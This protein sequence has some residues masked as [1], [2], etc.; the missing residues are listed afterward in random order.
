[1]HTAAIIRRIVSF[2]ALI[3]LTFG[4]D[5]DL[6]R[7]ESLY[8]RTE[9]EAAIRLLRGQQSQDTGSLL[10]LGKSY[11]MLGD[12]K[13]ATEA[14]LKARDLDPQ[15]SEIALWLGRTFGRR[16][17]TASPLLAPG[18]ASKA[19]QYFELAVNLDPTNKEA[20]DDLFDYYLQAP[21]FLGGGPEKAAAVAHRI[22]AL[23]AAEGHF[24]EA[25]IAQKR[26]EFD[27]AEEQLRRA[28]ALA[29][30][31]VGRVIDL[32]R[33]LAKR[34]R[35]QESDTVF[36]Q[37][38]QIAPNAPKLLFAKARVY[39]ETNRNLPNAKAL[40]LK[41]LQSSLTPDDPPKSEA[42]KLLQRVAGV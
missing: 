38:D 17:E 39:I 4:A 14:L 8:Q 24:A 42:E 34:G 28:M 19:R 9:Y 12:F 7:A 15:S 33:Y 27:T 32:A 11:F 21:A 29:P 36:Q 5:F 31:S 1:M 6:R 16:A 20:L 18:N 23:D 3:S 35:Y 37:A 25:Q 41:Y 30:R 26:K 10:V 2:F 22:A 40:L 13:K